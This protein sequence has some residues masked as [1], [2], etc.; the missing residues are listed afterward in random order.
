MSLI[1]KPAERRRKK[2]KLAIQGIAKS[3]KTMGALK[4]ARGLIGAEGKILL[5]DTEH[6]S[7]EIYSA[8]TP[9]D[10]C[11]LEPAD[12]PNYLLAIETAVKAGYDCL[13]LDSLSPAWGDVLDVADK[14]TLRSASKSSFDSWKKATPIYNNLIQAIIKAPIHIISTLRSKDDFVMEEYQRANGS[15]GVRPRKVG[16]A[17]IMRPG[18]SFEMDV[19]CT[20]DGE[21][22]LIVGESRVETVTDMVIPKVDEKFGETLRAFLESGVA[23]FVEPE[24][25]T[26]PQPETN[27]HT[28]PLDSHV[29]SIEHPMLKGKT[30]GSLGKATV[31][32][33]LAKTKT[34]SES[35]L[36]AMKAFLEL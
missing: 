8:V 7:A 18:F 21:H 3:G 16:L 1:I 17:A 9:F 10:H 4:I 13:I 15:M 20:V 34:A 25:V 35:D 14:Q 33:V 26:A 6:S 22:Q 28:H 31:Q 11:N 2:L 30:L 19:I 5:C 29:L 32:N 12:V 27:G 24:P 36:A 23:A